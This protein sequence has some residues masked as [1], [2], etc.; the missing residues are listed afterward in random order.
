MP[1]GELEGQMKSLAGRLSSAR[2]VPV[3]GGT[4]DLAHCLEVQDACV[5]PAGQLH[6]AL[7]H[8]PWSDSTSG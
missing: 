6:S 1:P 5:I 3:V 4:C 8:T 2:S 7:D